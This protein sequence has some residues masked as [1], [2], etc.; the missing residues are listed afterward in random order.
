MN[1]RGVALFVAVL[2]LG[3]LGAIAATLLGLTLTESAL[4]R[5]SL[6]VAQAEA[7]AEGAASEAWRGWPAG[8]TPLTPGD[9]L[10]V[11]RFVGASGEGRA[12][13][14]GLGGALLALEASAPLAR[15]SGGPPS[16]V[17]VMLII[18]LD[19][20]PGSSLAFPHLVARGW[21]LIPR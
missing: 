19:S 12:T 17:G 10:E 2:A 6:S 15:V 18:T 3:V 13:V 20:L 9:S 21:R 11:A 1:R 14:R 5:S 7:V 16:R 4:G 8:L